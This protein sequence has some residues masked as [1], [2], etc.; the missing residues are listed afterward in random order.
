MSHCSTKHKIQQQSEGKVRGWKPNWRDR[1]IGKCVNVVT[2]VI[3]RLLHVFEFIQLDCFRST[4]C[5]L[6]NRM[7]I[8]LASEW[9]A[10]QLKWIRSL[11]LRFKQ[12]RDLSNPDSKCVKRTIGFKICLSQNRH[13]KRCCEN[14]IKYCDAI[15]HSFHAQIASRKVSKL[16]FKLFSNHHRNQVQCAYSHKGH[17]GWA[18]GKLEREQKFN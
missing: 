13:I 2:K 9:C 14:C 3:I 16:T 6:L 1:K 4:E 5:N 12:F 11:I 18:T 15:P 8:E 17:S 10:F 7:W